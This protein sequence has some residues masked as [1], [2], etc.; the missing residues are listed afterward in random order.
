MS[1]ARAQP[2]GADRATGWLLVIG[3]TL[4]AVAAVVAIRTQV[5]SGAQPWSNELLDNFIFAKLIFFVL[6]L[7]VALGALRGFLHK[8]DQGTPR[9][10]VRFGAGT[11]ALYAVTALGIFLTLPTGMW[12]YLGGI[13]DVSAPIP[14]FLFYRAHYIGAA[15][16]L[17]A[18]SS[19]LSYWWLSD[20]RPLQVRRGQWTAH[21]RGLAD[22]LPRPVGD[23][24]ARVLRLDLRQ[25]PPPASQ[26]SFYEKVVAFPTWEVALTVITLTGIL[27]AIRFVIPIPSP[28][29]FLSSTL[30]VAAMV[31]IVLKV[32]D[33][34][35]CALRASSHL[36]AALLAGLWALANLVVA[37]LFI[38]NAFVAKT[39]AKEGLLAQLSLLGG[40]ALIEILAIALLWRCFRVV[41]PR[42]ANTT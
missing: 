13:L 30:H 4:A 21:L 24:M 8:A 31:L 20:D 3:G 5:D 19:F 9:E 6:G 14:L 16:I 25:P 39:V 32:L 18:T 40:G 2:Q 1:A 28:I 29:L 7:G 12:Q 10:G 41:F 42:R 11:S 36:T 26:F 35:R 37:F 27:K 38:T 33:H 15:L 34:L 23:L 22:E 17:L